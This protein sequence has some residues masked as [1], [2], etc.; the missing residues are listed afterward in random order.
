MVFI[1]RPV[2]IKKDDH[3]MGCQNVG[4]TRLEREIPISELKVVR[5]ADF[6]ATCIQELGLDV[7]ISKYAH[8]APGRPFFSSAVH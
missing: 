7:A 6:P 1:T 3:G 5:W 4:R 2:L 8:H